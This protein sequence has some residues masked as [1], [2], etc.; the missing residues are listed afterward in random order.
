MFEVLITANI[1]LSKELQPIVIESFRDRNILYY[2]DFE[3]EEDAFYIDLED[4]QRAKIQNKEI[5]KIINIPI[6]KVNKIRIIFK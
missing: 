2:R 6:N 4:A 1:Y 5:E 3:S